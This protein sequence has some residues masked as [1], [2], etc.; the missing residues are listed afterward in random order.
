MMRRL[1]RAKGKEGSVLLQ[2]VLFFMA[3][4]V[5]LLASQRLLGNTQ[6]NAS[7]KSRSL[8]SVLEAENASILL[9]ELLYR[10]IA[11]WYPKAFSESWAAV[12]PGPMRPIEAQKRAE[13]KLLNY[14]IVWN[15]TNRL[16]S[17]QVS[18]FLPNGVLVESVRL[19]QGI[20]SELRLRDGS[21][22]KEKERLYAF[23][24]VLRRDGKREDYQLQYLIRLPELA[25]EDQI[26]LE[27]LDERR[28]E[29]DWEQLWL[30]EQP[31]GDLAESMEESASESLLQESVR[32]T[33]EEAK[34]R[35]IA[36][37]RAAWLEESMQLQD[38]LLQRLHSSVQKGALLEYRRIEGL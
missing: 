32:P 28:L 25:Q 18:G 21:W 3:V 4:M 14:L 30:A 15:P 37:L 24:M 31:V 12:A 17:E 36:E 34:A 20:T 10:D 19:D 13:S 5:L 38:A 6:K 8:L 29:P 16:Q 35:R 22:G 11:D 26:A 1:D 23:R 9:D 33:E 7:L 27:A 2:A